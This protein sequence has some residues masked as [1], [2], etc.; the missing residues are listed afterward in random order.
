MVPIRSVFDLMDAELVAAVAALALSVASAVSVSA[1]PANIKLSANVAA[2]NRNSYSVA[3]AGSVPKYM[4][5][6]AGVSVAV[7]R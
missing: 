3:L 2:L 7:I 5:L 6:P 1:G 4:P